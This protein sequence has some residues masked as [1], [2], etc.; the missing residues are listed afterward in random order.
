[1]EPGE[2]AE[3]IFQALHNEQLGQQ[4]I[5]G[6]RVYPGLPIDKQIAIDE[7]KKGGCCFKKEYDWPLNF[8]RFLLGQ[9]LHG[10]FQVVTEHENTRFTKGYAWDVCIHAQELNYK[11]FS[12]NV[13]NIDPLFIAG[14][15]YG[16]LVIDSMTNLDVDQGSLGQKER[17]HEITE[18]FLLKGVAY[19]FPSLTDF[20]SSAFSRRNKYHVLLTKIPERYCVRVHN[21]NIELDEFDEGFHNKIE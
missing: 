14:K 11:F 5:P 6:D 19:Y 10:E 20:Q 12:T 18:L 3:R 17:Q 9:L 4:V 21:F 8:I 1:M 7:M 13:K 15:G 2:E 16:L